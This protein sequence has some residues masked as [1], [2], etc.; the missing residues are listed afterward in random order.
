MDN[1][2]KKEKNNAIDKTMKLIFFFKEKKNR[3]SLHKSRTSAIAAVHIR[4]L[5]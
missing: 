4:Y 1:Y 2:P 3:N 5:N